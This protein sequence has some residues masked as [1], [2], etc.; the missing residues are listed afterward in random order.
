M[1]ITNISE[2][3]NHPFGDNVAKEF[4]ADEK[5]QKFFDNYYTKVD[6]VDPAHFDIVRGFLIGKGFDESTIDN[7]S[8][9]LLEVAREQDINPVDLIKQLDDVDNKLKL[10]TLLC[11]LLNTTRNRTSILGYSLGKTVSSNIS[12]TILA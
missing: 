9:T 12:R 10:N 6:S 1:S 2:H 11:I 8:I 4:T 5:Q 7:L 3:T